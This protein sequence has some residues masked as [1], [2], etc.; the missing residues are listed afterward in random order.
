MAYRILLKIPQ[1]IR[2]SRNSRPARKPAAKQ[3][4]P[5]TIRIVTSE[6]AQDHFMTYNPQE[7]RK[8]QT[9]ETK[10]PNTTAFV[11]RKKED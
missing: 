11:K 5:Y 2:L 1:I 7:S 3:E 10:Y 8:T 6:P 9:A 4:I